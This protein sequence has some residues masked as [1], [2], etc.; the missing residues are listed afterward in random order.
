[1]FLHMQFITILILYGMVFRK[2]LS[3][4][5]SVEYFKFISFFPLLS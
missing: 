4:Q 2:D 5:F 3:Y 1:M